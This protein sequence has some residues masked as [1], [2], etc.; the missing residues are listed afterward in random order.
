MEKQ[1]LF[2][3]G[4]TWCKEHLGG[5]IAAPGHP[6]I[7]AVM[8]LVRF[9]GMSEAIHRSGIEDVRTAAELDPFIPATPTA[10]RAGLQVLE[11]AFSQGAETAIVSAQERWNALYQAGRISEG[12]V[13]SAGK[14]QAKRVEELFR[15]YLVGW[16]RGDPTQ[17]TQS[18][19]TAT[20]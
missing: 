3:A 2:E 4:R 15:A 18:T 12:H 1:K 14:F 9:R 16:Q 17:P 19:A 11:V 7:L 10:V 6:L 5:E 13:Y 20:C 8:V